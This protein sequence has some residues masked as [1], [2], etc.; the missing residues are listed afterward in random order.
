MRPRDIPAGH[1][2][3][4]LPVAV[5]VRLLGP[6][7]I[8]AGHLLRRHVLPPFRLVQL[9][10][11][12]HPGRASIETGI[13]GVEEEN[14]LS[15]RDIPAGHLLRLV[16]DEPIESLCGVRATSRPGIY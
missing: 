9:A 2:L 3:R 11:A 12:R 5:L 8:P 7:D 13:A 16:V 10:S 15:P 14:T 4:R 1:L 6:R